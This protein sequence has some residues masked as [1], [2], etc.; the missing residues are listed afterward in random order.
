MPE[1][2]V[3]P[4]GWLTD[5]LKALGKPLQRNIELELR[6]WGDGFMDVPE[7]ERQF[8][9]DITESISKDRRTKELS[10][11]LNELVST[12]REKNHNFSEL[13]HAQAGE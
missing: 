12:F 4:I 9:A 10:E 6:E 7:S 13:N 2:I 1:E 5:Y 8:Q 3:M 11:A